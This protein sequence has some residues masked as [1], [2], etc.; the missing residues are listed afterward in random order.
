M[1]HDDII[2]LAAEM[3]KIA[4]REGASF[5]TVHRHYPK[6][7]AAFELGFRLTCGATFAIGVMSGVALLIGKVLP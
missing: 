3:A 6:G 7:W 1:E 4:E 2:Q 5:V